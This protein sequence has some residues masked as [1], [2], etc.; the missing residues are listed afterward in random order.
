MSKRRYCHCRGILCFRQE[1]RVLLP[2]RRGLL[3]DSGNKKRDSPAQL[4]VVEQS[5]RQWAA[6]G[7]KPFGQGFGGS[8]LKEGYR[9]P[10]LTQGGMTINGEGE[11]DP[12]PPPCVRGEGEKWLMA[13]RSCVHVDYCDT[14]LA[15]KRR[16]FSLARAT[17]RVSAGTTA[18]RG[19]QR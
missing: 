19:A 15:L 13:M 9:D 4:V 6:G 18:T 16:S 3:P 5:V 8:P 17:C 1:G 7:W 2:R 12:G 10:C 14:L 11:K